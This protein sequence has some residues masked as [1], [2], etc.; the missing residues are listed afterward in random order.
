MLFAVVR[1]ITTSEVA[2]AVIV[3][4]CP[5]IILAALLFFTSW[6]KFR[7]QHILI[8]LTIGSVFGQMIVLGGFQP[9]IWEWSTESLLRL[10]LRGGE[11]AI[12]A[13]AVC[14]GMGASWL[15]LEFLGPMFIRHDKKP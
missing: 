1:E 4:L 2:W 14:A 8:A 12:S 13:F 6:G 9:P 5:A 15:S 7:A 10:Y 3:H 11:C